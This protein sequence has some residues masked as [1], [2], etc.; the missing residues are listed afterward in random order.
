MITNNY[1]HMYVMCVCVGMDVGVG[2]CKLLSAS[3]Y[4]CSL[5]KK[6]NNI[7]RKEG[8]LMFI[9]IYVV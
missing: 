7:Q 1:Y 3:L 6:E 5:F 2:E 9:H 4:V 8:C